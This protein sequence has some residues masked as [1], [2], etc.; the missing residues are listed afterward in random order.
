[1]LPWPVSLKIAAPAPVT[2]HQY[3]VSIAELFF[4]SS[5]MAEAPVNKY[6]APFAFTILAPSAKPSIEVEQARIIR[7]KECP[8]CGKQSL[9]GNLIN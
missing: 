9:L 3:V 7:D 5:I 1:M 4:Y 6:F 8:V 2:V